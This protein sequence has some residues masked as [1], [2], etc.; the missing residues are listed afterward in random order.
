MR[1]CLLRERD[2]RVSRAYPIEALGFPQE[3]ISPVLWLKTIG[4]QLPVFLVVSVEERQLSELIS[5]AVYN[6][7]NLAMKMEGYIMPVIAS[8]LAKALAISLTGVMSP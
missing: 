4:S 8:K 6:P 1:G 3:F 2:A 5:C 7:T